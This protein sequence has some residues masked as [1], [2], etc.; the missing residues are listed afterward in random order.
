MEAKKMLWGMY[1]EAL[2]ATDVRA[3]CKSRSFSSKEV[4]SSSLFETLFLS[5]TGLKSALESLTQDEIVLLHI[6]RFMD[7]AV[8]VTFFE[9]LYGN[10][11]SDSWHYQS[12]ASRYKEIFKKVR[13]SLVRKGVLL[14]AESTDTFGATKMERWRFRLPVEF[15]QFLPSPFDSPAT[16]DAMRGVYNDIR[17]RKIKQ[18]VNGAQIPKESTGYDL[19]LSHGKLF[20]GKH[21]FRMNY[22]EK[23]Q[24]ESWQASALKNWNSKTVPPLQLVIY[25]LSQLNQNEWIIPDDLTRFW[26]ILYAEEEAPDSIVICET[27]WEWGYLSK[28]E[29]GGVSYYRLAGSQDVKTVEPDS[30]L[31]VKGNK[32]VVIDLETIPC[33]NFDVLARISTM[34][35]LDSR[36]HISPDLISIGSAPSRIRNHPQTQWLRNN[37]TL[38]RDV[39]EKV[40]EK[41]GK[42]VI[43]DNL[44]VARIRDI[45]LV[46]QIQQSFSERKHIVA[47]S[48]DFIA[49]PRT[50]YP[51]LQTFV[52]GA[53]YVIK[54]VNAVS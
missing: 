42:L 36:I 11:E 43:H 7:N 47:L 49:F 30:Y 32:P 19:K 31:T 5:E 26:R 29:R 24:M 46:V 22:L 10:E 40:D 34:E 35:I 28:H 51:K 45:S 33:E 3:I 38:F 41:W 21:E 13:T 8:D 6:L 37:S 39:L 1:D 54:T 27:G 44:L 20:I 23:W 25:A 12:F 18:V 15:Y 2:T 17:R 16:F 50:V 48:K 52:E 14:F 4:Y 9:R 53:G